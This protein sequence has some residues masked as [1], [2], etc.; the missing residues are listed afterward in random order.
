MQ[1]KD[2]I[3][4]FANSETVFWCFTSSEQYMSLPN[5]QKKINIHKERKSVFSISKQSTWTYFQIRLPML[6]IMQASVNISRPWQIKE[7]V[8][9]VINESPETDKCCFGTQEFLLSD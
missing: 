7:M 4:Y 2:K 9:N 6:K 5:L 3:I 1:H 8:N